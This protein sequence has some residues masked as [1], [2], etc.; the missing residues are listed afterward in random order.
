MKEKYEILFE[1]FN[2]KMKT[3]IIAT[4]EEQARSILM[5]K[6]IFHKVNKKVDSKDMDSDEMLGKFK[7]LFSSDNP[8]K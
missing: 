7:D 5:G 1:I 4:S 8:F 2:K 3:T 6:I